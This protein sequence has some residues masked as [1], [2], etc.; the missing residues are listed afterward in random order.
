MFLKF[1]RLKGQVVI[2]DRLV[3]IEKT[4]LKEEVV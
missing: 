1:L 4:L 3:S 2:G